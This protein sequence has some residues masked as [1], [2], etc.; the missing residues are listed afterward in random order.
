[1]PLGQNVGGDL[2]SVGVH[3]KVELAPLPPRATVLLGVP[4]ALPEQLQA[5]AVQH[6]MHGP[7]VPGNT[8]LTTSEGATTPGQ[9]GM[10]RDGQL[11]AEQAQH[12]AAER[13][14]LAQGQVE[15]E[16]QDQHQLDCQVGVAWLSARRSPARRLPASECCLVKPERQVTAPLQ[17]GL[18]GGPVRHP[19][20]LLRD[21]VTADGVVLERHAAT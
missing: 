15:D 11:E 10:I 14:G 9:G 5:G 20:T 12:A 7:F 6:E 8:R 18:V 21:A 17:P 3:G 13:F 1:M 4:L 19:E 16:P 2:A